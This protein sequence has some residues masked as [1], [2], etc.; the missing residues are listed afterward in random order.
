MLIGVNQWTDDLCEC[1]G[2]TMEIG[3]FPDYVGT[4]ITFIKDEKYSFIDI[5]S[6]I[7]GM[8]SIVNAFLTI[9]LLYL[10]WGFD[11]NLFK[12]NGI[13][14]NAVPDHNNIQTKMFKKLIEAV[15]EEK[16]KHKEISNTIST[17]TKK[18]I[19]E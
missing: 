13:N 1:S 15:A 6:S 9:F 18:S 17:N 4:K 8:F 14:P 7:G 2:L 10:I 19:D 5:F 3:L 11:F 12:F 16:L